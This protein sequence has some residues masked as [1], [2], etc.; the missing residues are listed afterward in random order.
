MNRMR[1]RILG[2]IAQRREAERASRG[3]RGSLMM[4]AVVM[5][6]V[7]MV[8]A[9]GTIA[10]NQTVHVSNRK[11]QSTDIAAQAARGLLEKIDATT[12]DQVGMYDSDY[13]GVSYDGDGDGTAEPVVRFAG[14][15]P[16]SAWPTGPNNPYVEIIQGTQISMVLYIT[17]AAQGAAGDCPAGCG[18]ATSP[19]SYGRKRITVVVTYDPVGSAPART[20]TYRFVRNALPREA[21]PTTFPT[22]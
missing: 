10:L 9:A 11:A 14:T 12:W 18:L 1:R 22:A 5:M 20:V 21:L 7:V 16:G 8:I 15:R 3:Q 13:S 4:E 19:G 17:W 6:L 2:R